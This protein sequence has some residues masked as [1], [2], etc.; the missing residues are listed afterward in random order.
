MG[1]LLERNRD[2]TGAVLIREIEKLASEIDR[3]LANTTG[4]I[5]YLFVRLDWTK[6]V[7]LFRMT[8]VTNLVTQTE[9]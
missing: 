4:R 3:F 9:R 6:V 5:E 8:I 2:S 7:R 1:A